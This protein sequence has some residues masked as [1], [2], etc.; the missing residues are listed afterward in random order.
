MFQNLSAFP[1]ETDNQWE[2]SFLVACAKYAPVNKHLSDDLWVDLAL[3]KYQDQCEKLFQDFEKISKECRKARDDES[4]DVGQYSEVYNK[5]VKEKIHILGIKPK[6]NMSLKTHVEE[7]KVVAVS[8]VLFLS[9]L[10]HRGEGIF[11]LKTETKRKNRTLRKVTKLKQLR[12]AFDQTRSW[13]VDQKNPHHFL[14]Q[15]IV[16]YIPII[17]WIGLPLGPRWP[18]YFVNVVESKLI[19]AVFI[20]PTDRKIWLRN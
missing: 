11:P 1:T 10:C 4:S 12:E 18:I 19:L 2:E 20:F 16:I 13:E 8:T 7:A 15:L 9:I 17:K 14:N 3:R 5:H 6:Q